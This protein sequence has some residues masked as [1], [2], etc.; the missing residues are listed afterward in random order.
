MKVGSCMTPAWRELCRC[1]WR[2][3]FGIAHRGCMI[4]WL[5]GLS[6][7]SVVK[8]WLLRGW[9]LLRLSWHRLMV[10]S[11]FHRCRTILFL[12]CIGNRNRRLL[13]CF[14]HRIRTRIVYR[15]R[16]FLDKRRWLCQE[17]QLLPN[18]SLGY[19][20]CTGFHLYTWHSTHCTFCIPR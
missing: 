10:L 14:R 3:G 6:I 9:P 16:I 18:W 11:Q 5:L 8:V 17:C 13:L 7:R 20:L 1:S 4:R 2:K 19:I 12:R 15:H